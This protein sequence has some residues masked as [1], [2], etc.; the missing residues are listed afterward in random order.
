MKHV[1]LPVYNDEGMELN[2]HLEVSVEIL[3]RLAKTSVIYKDHVKVVPG[4]TA[5]QEI[6]FINRIMCGLPTPTPSAHFT[7]EKD[8]T[9]TQ[10][11]RPEEVEWTQADLDFN[12]VELIDVV[13]AYPHDEWRE[14]PGFSRYEMHGL[15]QIIREKGTDKDVHV[16]QGRLPSV[17]LTNDDGIVK[18]MLFDFLLKQTFPELNF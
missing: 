16:V 3:Q 11:V 8:G 12:K 4:L 15:V 17:L 7:L 14:I 13:S 6:D 5:E 1:R 9:V 10:H 18:R 2:E